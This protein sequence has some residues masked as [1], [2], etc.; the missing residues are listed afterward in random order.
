M[1]IEVV[2]G[3]DK[4]AEAEVAAADNKQAEEQAEDSD[5]LAQGQLLVVVA[6]NSRTFNESM[7]GSAF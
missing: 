3:H 4:R 7:E 2:A 5:K 1:H 6:G